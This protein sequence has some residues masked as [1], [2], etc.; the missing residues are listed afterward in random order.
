M[1]HTH[2]PWFVDERFARLTFVRFLSRGKRS[3]TPGGDS[4]LSD[5][6]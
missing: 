6:K 3:S 4:T 2:G 5:F 1:I